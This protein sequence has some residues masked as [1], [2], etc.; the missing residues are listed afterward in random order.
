MLNGFLY[1]LE[2]SLAVSRS[3][4]TTRPAVLWTGQ[5]GIPRLTMTFGVVTRPFSR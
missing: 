2:N 3:I 4:G 1:I 5:L